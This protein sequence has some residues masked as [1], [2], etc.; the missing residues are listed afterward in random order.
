MKLREALRDAAGRL[1]AVSETPRLDAELLAAF[2]LGCDRNAL[3]LH[4]L[5]GKVPQGFA[6]LIARRWASEPVAYI[7]GQ[8]DFWS[9]NLK[10]A[11]GVLIPRPDS[12]TLIEAAL[13]HFGPQAPRTV[14]DLGTGSGAL[15][16]AALI[17][18]SEATGL[19]VDR[20]AEALA[21]ATENAHRC[22]LAQRAVFQKGNW[23]E[24]VD[25]SF[26]LVLCN[27]P[28]IEA[29]CTL[30]RDVVDY[31]PA[32]ALFAGVDGLDDYRVLAPQIGRL[33]APS[34]C[35]CIEIGHDQGESA[36]ALFRAEGLSVAVLQDLGARDRCLIVRHA[37]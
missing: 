37:P 3:L 15:L 2:A 32:E 10:V 34:G 12:E 1:E 33:L 4:H 23:A 24:G 14:L 19:G 29:G 13:A 21:T 22:G 26:D 11:P 36:A 17:E 35:A 31:E 20:S 6:D 27:P 9:L 7:T 18:Y 30:P 5:D 25:G 28:Y 8:R 16:L